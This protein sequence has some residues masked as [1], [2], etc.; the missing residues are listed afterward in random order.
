MFDVLFFVLYV[1]G[2]QPVLYLV[3]VDTIKL[4]R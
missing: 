2:Y 3:Y 1:V 4:R